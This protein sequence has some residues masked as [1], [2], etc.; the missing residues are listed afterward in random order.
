MFLEK[1]FSF[2][3]IET[4][5]PI[6]GRNPAIY[7]TMCERGLIQNGKSEDWNSSEYWWHD[8]VY[9]VVL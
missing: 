1:M 6:R 8:F 2:Y 7:E 5:T 3:R 9:G 4:S